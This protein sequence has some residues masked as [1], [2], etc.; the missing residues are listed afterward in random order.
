M[1][2]PYVPANAL[3]LPRYR[4]EAAI[5]ALIALLDAADP[6]PDLEPS[7]GW[8]ERQVVVAHADDCEADDDVEDDAV[9]QG[10]ADCVPEMWTRPLVYGER[11]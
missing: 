3:A 1:P 2:T 6:D 4:I 10:D 9:D 5:E 7:L 8:T 11:P